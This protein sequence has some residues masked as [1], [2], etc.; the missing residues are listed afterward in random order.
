MLF[1][2]VVHFIGIAASL[3]AKVATG[4]A[5]AFLFMLMLLTCADVAL[6]YLFNKPILGSFELTEFM[7]AII[8]GLALAYCAL[9]KG[10]VRVDLVISRLPERAQAVMEGLANFC[11]LFLFALITWRIIP[12]AQQ[13]M[14]AGQLTAI[15][16]IPVFPFVLVV[17]AGTAVL[18]IVLLKIFIDDLSKL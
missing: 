10:H 4:I 13:M 5:A 7:M 8:V 1:G 16:R 15:L 2:K 14:E 3:T 18:C 6:R 12:R 11:F 9:M 17:A